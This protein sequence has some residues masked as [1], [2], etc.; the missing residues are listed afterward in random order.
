[1]SD[2]LT[3]LHVTDFHL[4]AS[5][6][7]PSLSTPELTTAF[8]DGL[9]S[10]AQEKGLHEIDLIVAT[11]DF[12]D[13]GNR[14]YFSTA[15]EH[16]EKLAQRF[17]VSLDRIVGCCGNH[18][19]EHSYQAKGQNELARF[20]FFEFIENLAR[21]KDFEGRFCQF[22]DFPEINLFLV[23]LDTTWG[24]I[25]QD[26]GNFVAFRPNR[27]VDNRVEHRSILTRI[28]DEIKAQRKAGKACVILSHYPIEDLPDSTHFESQKRELH[29]AREYYPLLKLLEQQNEA[30]PV[31]F[32]YGDV[33]CPFRWDPK[34]DRRGGPVFQFAT[35]RLDSPRS[36]LQEWQIQ[37][38]ARILRLSTSGKRLE[39]V[40]LDYEDTHTPSN[41]DPQ[42][43]EWYSKDWVR[44]S[45]NSWQVAKR[46]AKWKSKNSGRT[47]PPNKSR[48]YVEIGSRIEDEIRELGLCEY[49]C[50]VNGEFAK[51]VHIRLGPLMNNTT[52]INCAIED[53][54]ARISSEVSPSTSF[55]FVGIDSWGTW[56]AT[57][58]GMRMGT[59]SFG[60]TLRGL[61]DDRV[62]Y[63]IHYRETA[64]RL[65]KQKVSTVIFV[66][67]VSVTYA[68]ATRA[69]RILSDSCKFGSKIDY[70]VASLIT[71]T[72]SKLVE[73]HISEFKKSFSVLPDFPIPV[74][75]SSDF[76]TRLSEDRFL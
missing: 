29:V 36:K 31:V 53:L 47:V 4:G 70:W 67:D 1:M 23:S 72:P 2:F 52:L 14:E 18:D 68:S 66:A 48:P 74:L 24:S 37:P 44:W 59:S 21:G 17:G 39:T 20:H 11:G 61:T 57:E 62:E 45:P 12:V 8:F 41:W 16:L 25:S 28:A 58:L 38:G 34:F 5:D 60:I 54:R 3:L 76:P 56:L 55:S 30:A 26:F 75:P 13:C 42:E 7:I 19:Y 32:L 35:S 22:H 9:F 15:K 43:S 64:E 33:H 65:R 6:G 63:D 10:S 27:F 40:R 69:K 73:K 51:T 46:P 50:Y 49:G 71:A